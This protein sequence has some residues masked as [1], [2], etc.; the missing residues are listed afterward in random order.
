MS[1]HTLW[2]LIP[3]A[4]AGLLAT[5]Q[6]RYGN[7]TALDLFYTFAAGVVFWDAVRILQSKTERPGRAVLVTAV[8]AAVFFV[9]MAVYVEPDP[10]RIG[11]LSYP[12]M[13]AGIAFNGVMSMGMRMP[14]Y[15]RSPR[16]CRDDFNG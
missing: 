7:P 10:Y 1:I 15:L 6:Y 13:V 9:C 2:R 11:A 4:L 5:L 14:Q 12:V 8:L 16:T 3:L